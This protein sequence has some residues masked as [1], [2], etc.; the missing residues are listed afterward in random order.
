MTEKVKE[1]LKKYDLLLVFIFILVVAAIFRPRSFYNLRNLS[2]ILK[3]SALIGIATLGESLV[4]LIRGVD[5]SVGAVMGFTSL[6][7]A[8]LLQAGYGLLIAII[9][10]LAICALIGFMNGILIVKGKIPPIITTLGMMW[11]LRGIGGISP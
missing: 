6:L 10:P 11:L 1:L 7:V 8:L 3:L 5:I 9:L 2:S 4:L